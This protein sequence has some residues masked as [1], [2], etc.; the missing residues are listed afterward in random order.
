LMVLRLSPWWI[1]T[2][3]IGKSLYDYM[4]S[5]PIRQQLPVF[6]YFL[7]FLTISIYK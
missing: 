2:L 1:Y 7:T 5:R 4:M 6:L 3:K